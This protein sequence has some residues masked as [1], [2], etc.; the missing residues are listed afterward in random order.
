MMELLGRM[1]INIAL[2]GK[3][4]KKYFDSKGKL[5]KLLTTQMLS[6]RHWDLFKDDSKLSPKTNKNLQMK[7]KKQKNI[8]YK[9]HTKSSKIRNDRCANPRQFRDRKV[10]STRVQIKNI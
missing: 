7:S 5:K 4:S 6:K 2:S 10:L 8:P 3:D 9:K 1:P